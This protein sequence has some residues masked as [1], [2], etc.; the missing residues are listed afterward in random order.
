MVPRPI[1][2]FTMNS[3]IINKCQSGDRSE[4]LPPQLQSGHAVASGAGE[5]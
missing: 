3:A 4:N 1:T 5:V 2:T